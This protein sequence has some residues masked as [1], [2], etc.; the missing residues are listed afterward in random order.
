VVWFGPAAYPSSGGSRV[1]GGIETGALPLHARLG[2]R[3]AA[4]LLRRLYHVSVS[5]LPSYKAIRRTDLL[6]L[7]IRDLRYGWTAELIAR[8]AQRGLRIRE[9]PIAY[10]VRLGESK[11]SGNLRASLLAGL[12]ILRAV[13]GVR[14][15]RR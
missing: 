11:V 4:L 2:N 6:A 15:E 1:S 7:D 10:R 13:V 14:F 9:V 12:A 5:D 8:A 3:L